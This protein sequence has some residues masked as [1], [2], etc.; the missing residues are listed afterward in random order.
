MAL[1]TSKAAR[2]REECQQV[3][4]VPTG[5]TFNASITRVSFELLAQ[6]LR[7][8]DMS[9]SARQIECQAFNHSRQRLKQCNMAEDEL[10]ELKM[11]NKDT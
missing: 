5:F 9:S 8:S 11:A 10:Y 7:L 6:V 1:E 4:P 3:L 2:R